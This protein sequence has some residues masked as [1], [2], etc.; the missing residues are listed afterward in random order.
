M[1]LAGCTQVA[2]D[3]LMIDDHSQAVSNDVWTLYKYALL[4]FGAVA[5]LIE[6]DENLP[7]WSTLIAE[8]EKARAIATSVFTASSMDVTHDIT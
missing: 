2:K 1:H 8:A 6:W 7:S 3:E 5:T 4:Q